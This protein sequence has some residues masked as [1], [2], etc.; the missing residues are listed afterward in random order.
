MNQLI[1][2]YFGQPDTHGRLLDDILQWEDLELETS[3][4]WV[5]WVFPNIEPSLVTPDTPTLDKETISYW[6][7]SPF[8]QGALRITVNRYV[9][10]LL[11]N[12]NIWVK[13][14]NHNHL[15]ITRMLNCM[16]SLGLESEASIILQ[17]LEDVCKSEVN[18]LSLQYWREA[19]E[20]PQH[21]ALI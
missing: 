17:R 6:R 15:R 12:K 4:D 7:Q 14:F 18:E 1:H 9:K 3:H 8:L 11:N 5:Q 21:T 13:K 2:F 20:I 10:F 19:I 16:M